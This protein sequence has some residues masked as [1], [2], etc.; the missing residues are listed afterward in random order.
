VKL[1]FLLGLFLYAQSVTEKIEENSA[2]LLGL[3]YTNDPLGEEKG[4]DPDPRF[5]AD[6]F[7][8]TTYVESVVAL[9]VRRNHED[10]RAVMDQ[11]RYKYGVVDFVQRNHFTSTDWIP[12]NVQAG[13]IKDVTR[14]LFPDDA[15]KSNTRIDRSAWFWKI[16]KL[17]VER[18]VVRS[19]LNYV[20]ADAFL[21]DPEK[22][23]RIP[24]GTIVTFL[25][26]ERR[27]VSR[28]GTDYDVSHQGFL[29]HKDGE[30]YLRHASSAA[31]RVVE[32]RFADYLRKFQSYNPNGGINL[33]AVQER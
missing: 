6:T 5:R 3:P 15:K 16:H 21:D 14:E 30:L 12:N 28:I 29:I 11:I 4:R 19:N 9:S 25:N 13:F 8:C 2:R 10:I 7:D 31:G 33:T 23:Q 26:P 17:R 27:L 20:R 18:P 22:L 24:S 32:E 1:W